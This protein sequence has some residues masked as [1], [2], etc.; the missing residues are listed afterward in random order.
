MSQH[1]Y[2]IANG[3]GAAVRA[4]INNALLAILSQNSGA[5]APTTTKPF[6]PWYDT[7]TGY[8]KM[9]NSAD[10]AWIGALQAVSDGAITKDASGNVGIGTSSPSYKLHVSGTGYVSSYMTVGGLSADTSSALLFRGGNGS[11]AMRIDSGGSLLV[12]CTSSPSSSVA[13]VALKSPTIAYSVWSSGSTTSQIYQIGFINGNGL[14]G[15]IETNGSSTSFVTSSD[16]RL[17]HDV[18]PIAGALERVSRLKPVTYKWNAD[19]SD[20]EGFLAH[21]LAEVCPLAVSGEK[22]DTEIE[23]YEISPAVPATFD[24]EG[25]ELTP[26]VEAVMGERE[27]PKYQGID[28]SFLVATLTAAIQEQQAIITSLTERIAALE[29]ANV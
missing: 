21:E 28:T 25:N 22:D 11:E 5:T 19:D 29:N 4:D 27:V 20:G 23:Q 17:K 2:N 8:Y 18:Q 9:R 26:A 15:R 16:Y 6:M 13:G 24:D 12:N 10:S 14:V 3:G 7:T 1:D